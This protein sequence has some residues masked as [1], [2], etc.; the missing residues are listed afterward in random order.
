MQQKI[1][2]KITERNENLKQYL[3]MSKQS[4]VSTKS[5]LFLVILTRLKIHCV[6]IVSLN[7]FHTFLLL[8][9]L[10]LNFVKK[11]CKSFCLKQFRAIFSSQYTFI[12]FQIVGVAST[13]KI[14]QTHNFLKLLHNY[15]FNLNHSLLERNFTFRISQTDILN[16]KHKTKNGCRHM[17]SIEQPK[18]TVRLFRNP[19]ISFCGFKNFLNFFRKFRLGIIKTLSQHQQNTTHNSYTI[20]PR[21]RL[22][23]VYFFTYQ[24]TLPQR[25]KQKNNYC[26]LTRFKS[27]DQ[28]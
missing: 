20:Q 3:E 23:R 25:T 28:L 26:L 5:F 12:N 10:S 14:S 16:D 15:G 21:K 8:L 4:T 6:K 7:N 24:D 17:H 9:F 22:N 13:L 2:L 18:S 27:I 11:K 19:K 1:L